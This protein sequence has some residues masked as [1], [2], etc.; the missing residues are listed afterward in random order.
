MY[1]F[2]RNLKDEFEVRD[3]HSLLFQIETQIFRMYFIQF[4]TDT[5]LNHLSSISIYET[6]SHFYVIGSNASETRFS[7][8]KIDRNAASNEFVAGE[9]DH[10][11]SKTEV[12]ELLS[13]ISAS[14]G[15]Y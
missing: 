1:I 14:S 13:T 6:P 5:M 3:S 12:A 7:T 2:I 11:Y 9:P 10:D 15:K 4:Q 8:L